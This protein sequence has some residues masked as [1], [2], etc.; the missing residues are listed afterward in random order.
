MST[1]IIAANAMDQV[2]PL[3][4]FLFAGFLLTFFFVW[5]GGVN[6]R[7]W[8]WWK[9][10]RRHG[11]PAELL[12]DE[13]CIPDWV[14]VG[15]W[16]LGA[17]ILVTSTFAL[18][19]GITLTNLFPSGKGTVFNILSALFL[20]LLLP[21]VLYVFAIVIKFFY[22]MLV[23]GAAM[24]DDAE[25]KK[26]AEAERARRITN[27]K[28]ALDREPERSPLCYYRHLWLADLG[29]EPSVHCL[30]LL[31]HNGPGLALWQEAYNLLLTANP[32]RESLAEAQALAKQRGL[33]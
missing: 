24:R 28:A 30:H 12:A 23:H 33:K 6:T 3:A 17:L 4:L 31:R 1:L 8:Y 11:L 2:I 27:L 13:V 10:Q 19:A 7:L 21:G 18:I 15:F 16:P 26:N 25:T 22:N 20:L 5:L 14:A 9:Y 32:G 29:D